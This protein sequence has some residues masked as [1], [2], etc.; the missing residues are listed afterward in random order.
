MWL[1]GNI[2]R[3]QKEMIVRVVPLRGHF[4]ATITQPFEA[5]TPTSSN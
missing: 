1:Y 2:R 5:L 4:V 3:A